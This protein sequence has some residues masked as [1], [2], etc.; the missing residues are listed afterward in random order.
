[1][2]TRLTMGSGLQ[3][4]AGWVR[5]GWNMCLSL[6]SLASCA[7]GA[8]N[9]PGCDPSPES[10]VQTRVTRGSHAIWVGAPELADH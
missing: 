2:Y 1:M 9:T 8:A 10:G 5:P 7:L 3:S 6:P 4:N